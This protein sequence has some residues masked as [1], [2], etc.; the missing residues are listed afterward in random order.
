MLV[1]VCIFVLN[2]FSILILFYPLKQ[3]MGPDHVDIITFY[4]EVFIPDVKP[5]LVELAPTGAA[6][7]NK[8]IAEAT[9]SNDCKSSLW[10]IFVK[11]VS[12][13]REFFSSNLT[14]LFCQ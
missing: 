10:V 4:N 7:K 6:Q 3:K 11:Y 2:S 8:N 5:L 14:Y 1:F 13:A 9:N 12:L